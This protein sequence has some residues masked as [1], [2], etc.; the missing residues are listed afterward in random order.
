MEIV[1]VHNGS[2]LAE[3]I[4][5]T[6]REQMGQIQDIRLVDSGSLDDLERCCPNL[7]MLASDTPSEFE[8]LVLQTCRERQFS[9]LSVLGRGSTVLVGPLETP[10]IPGCV[11]CLELRWEN[12]FERS[13][14][15]SIFSP[16][17]A[18]DE[19]SSAMP[20]EMSPS[21]LSILGNV[22]IDEMR[23][24]TAESL[25]AP[26]CKGH[27]GVL[28]DGEPFQ[29]VPVVPSHDCP[30][31]NLKPDDDPALAQCQFASHIVGD[32]EALRV[33][34]LDFKRLE[35]LFIHHKVGYIS[36]ANAYSNE[37]RYVQADAYIYTPA[38]A[39]I[40]GYG[41]GLS[42]TDAKQS[43]MLEVLERSCGFEAVNRRPVVFGKHSDF[44]DTAVHPLQ[45]G[46]HS[47][48]LY[49]S[50]HHRLEPFDE[51]KAYSWVWAYSTKYNRPVLVPEQIAYYGPTADEKRFVM[52]T[53]NGC[54]IGGTVEEAALHG[55][56]EVIE[57]D[58][59]LNM[60]YAKMPLPEL[61]LGPQCPTKVSEVFDYLTEKGFEVRLF[62]M[63]HDLAI[64]TIC[65][66]AVRDKDDYPKVVCGSACHINPYQAAYG[67]L[68]E[69]TVQVL[70]LLRA[71]EERRKEAFSMF[72]D[73]T[74]I[75]D[76]L[77]HVAVAALPEA[78]SRWA[79]LLRRENQGRIRAIEDEYAD[80][81]RQYQIDSRDIRRILNSV[82]EDL[83]GRGFDVI[84]ID[85]TS[86]EVAYGGLH[87]VKALIPGMT[88]ITFGYGFQR[89]RGL[90]RL[91]E[92]PYRMGYAEKVLTE[93]DLNPDCHPF[94]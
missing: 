64:P 16:F 17:A 1:L 66:V 60:W 42:I 87:A 80:A 90:S 5:D 55:M 92:L 81:A 10:G 70:N 28:D 29:W 62:R 41:S 78:Y 73:P 53:S 30:R 38:G 88:P 27:V 49:Q 59:F 39:E 76:I 86:V 37:D 2:V 74:K 69:L 68:R 6:W 4:S 51:E 35:R 93:E 82:F 89:V 22:V 50:S 15:S 79:F 48:E 65:A 85:Q 83:H 67:A 31:C 63:S 20:L 58:G 71:P 84:V 34:T 57:R 13:L 45:F 56:F 44:H 25:H 33:K 11:T 52:Q 36:A 3:Q 91:F 54:A 14:L 8:H 40:A 7:V 61:M 46:L 26:H 9:V 12:T 18:D 94:S 72:L 77:D 24:I 43:A 47:D 23:S 19:E 32:A 75:R 21:A